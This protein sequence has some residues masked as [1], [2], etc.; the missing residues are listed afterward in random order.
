M[1]LYGG[2]VQLVQMALF[3]NGG[4]RVGGIETWILKRQRGFDWVCWMQMG[5]KMGLFAGGE[6]AVGRWPR[7]EGRG[8]WS[9]LLLSPISTGGIAHLVTKMRSAILQNRVF[10]RITRKKFFVFGIF[11]ILCA[12]H[13]VA[14]GS[15]MD[16]RGEGRRRFF[17]DFAGFGWG[18][19][20]RRQEG[21]GE[22]VDAD[23]RS[24]GIGCVFLLAD[25][26][27]GWTVR[28]TANGRG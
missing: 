17:L 11:S 18:D 13:L 26:V 27:F 16:G 9:S 23:N 22:S 5:L 3:G 24:V 20:N 19:Q 28:Q 4:I 14:R 25:T 2:A 6:L 21:T 7:T 1:Y 15:E 12:A 10:D 8:R